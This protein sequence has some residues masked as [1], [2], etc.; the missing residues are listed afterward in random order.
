M[1]SPFANWTTGHPTLADIPAN[2][3]QSTGVGAAQTQW[4]IIGGA[5]SAGGGVLGTLT[6]YTGTTGPTTGWRINQIDDTY[7]MAANAYYVASATVNRDNTGLGAI[8]WTYDLMASPVTMRGWF[9]ASGANP[10]TWTEVFRMSLTKGFTAK[11]NL[12]QSYN[13]ASAAI[14]SNTFQATGWQVGPITVQNNM[15]GVKVHWDGAYQI[16]SLSFSGQWALF[17]TSNGG[18][19]PTVGN[20]PGGSDTNIFASLPITAPATATDYYLSKDWIDSGAAAGGVYYYYLAAL[21]N[22]SA[23]SFTLLNVTMIAED[24]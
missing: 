23:Q 24:L 15:T 10:I 2:F 8:A 18:S 19:P 12:L 1:A 20:P 21:S 16:S 22:S 4:G 7:V 14:S 3:A 5:P 9:V 6:P 11:R 13:N 17:R